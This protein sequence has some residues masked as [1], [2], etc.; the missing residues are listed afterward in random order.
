MTGTRLHDAREWGVKLYW[1]GLPETASVAAAG[2]AGTS[3]GAAFF[4]RKRDARRQREEAEA[5]LVQCVAA[6]HRRLSEAARAAVANPLQPPA[7]H[8][9]PGEMVLN[10][11][12]LVPRA[13][14]SAWRTHLSDLAQSHD[15]ARI[16]LELTGPWAPYNFTG[17]N[18]VGA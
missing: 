1:A 6:S 15:D 11:A 5:A 2:T 8:Q 14:E 4:Q 10:A 13:D 12:Y 9:R 16:S 7:V 18:L 3:P 17:S